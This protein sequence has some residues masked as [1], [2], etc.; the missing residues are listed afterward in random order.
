ML[1]NFVDLLLIKQIV[2]R[3]ERSPQKQSSTATVTITLQDLNDNTPRFAQASYST[4]VREN[5][6]VGSVIETIT[7]GNLDVIIL[8]LHVLVPFTGN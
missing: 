1:E 6:E 7:V 4:S 3:E 2:A 8:F 5:R